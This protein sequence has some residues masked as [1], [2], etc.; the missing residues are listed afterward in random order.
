M[1]SSLNKGTDCSGMDLY[2]SLEKQK[3]QDKIVVG[4]HIKINFFGNKGVHGKT[5]NEFWGK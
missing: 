5:L 1:T 3:M 4:N 2:K